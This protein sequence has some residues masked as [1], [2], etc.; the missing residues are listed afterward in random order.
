MGVVLFQHFTFCQT[1]MQEATSL[2]LCVGKPSPYQWSNSSFK[3]PCPHTEMVSQH[4]GWSWWHPESMTEGAALE[5]HITIIVRKSSD[6][7]QWWFLAYT[8]LNTWRQRCHH[9]LWSRVSIPCN[10]NTEPLP[11]SWFYLISF[12]CWRSVELPAF[13]TMSYGFLVVL[14]FALNNMDQIY[15][16]LYVTATNSIIHKFLLLTIEFVRL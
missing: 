5:K 1:T 9:R 8:I 6:F 15:Y 10:N 13:T 12:L 14:Y 16:N 2:Q 11:L 7:G 4:W 3:S